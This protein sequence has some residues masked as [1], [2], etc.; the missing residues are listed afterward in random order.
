MLIY[1]KRGRWC[2]RDNSG[3]LYKFNTESEAKKFAGWVPP[4]EETLN[5]SETEEKSSKKET[6]PNKQKTVLSSKGSSK[7][8]I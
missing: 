4:V 7:K 8:K 3:K 6:S 5:G 1:E 2:L